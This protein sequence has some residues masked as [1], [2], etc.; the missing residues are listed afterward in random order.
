MEKIR[1]HSVL[2]VDDEVSNI[3]ALTHIL[4]KEYV[5]YASRDGHDALESAEEHLPDVILLDIIMPEM[6]G[7][8]VL[9][10][11]KSSEI[12]RDIPV[13]FVTGLRESGD[14]ERGLAMGAA[15]YIVKPFSSALVRLRVR[16]QI[17][18]IEKIKKTGQAKSAFLANMS[19]EV[20]T[21]MN[22]VMGITE[23]LLQNEN[24]P[25]EL[26]DG[27]GRIYSSCKMLLGIINDILDF[28]KID[29]GML[30]ILPTRYNVAG[31]INDCVH[32]N[33]LRI[34]EKPIEF[35]VLAD[36]NTPAELIGDGLR[37]KQI[38]NNILSN[39]FK[40]TDSG[41]ITLS[42]ESQPCDEGTTLILSIS[43][44]G[45]GMTSEQVNKLFDE[46]SRFD[47]AH[48][49]DI[50]G[51]GLGMAITQ[52]LLRLMDGSIR[53]ESKPG[54]GSDFTVWLPQKTVSDEVIG[55]ELAEGLH[56]F[57][58]GYTADVA[59][60]R[61]VRE[62]MP[63]G[64]VLIVDDVEMNLYVADGL[65]RLYGLQIDLALSGFEA[66][67][68]IKD[69]KDYDIVFMD[70]IMPKMDGIETAKR[71][72]ELGYGN[73]IIALTANA[74]VGQSD[75]FLQNGFDDFISKPIDIRVLDVILKSLIRD[76]QPPKIQLQARKELR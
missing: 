74:V 53:V 19:H 26:L 5:L 61:F 40:Y 34:C 69:G 54:R 18:L 67:E 21:P 3:L 57:R 29:A 48:G 23:I 39:A 9:S 76:K 71:L 58:L 17:K 56:C 16:N 51:T 6:D 15:D 24:Y 46:Y 65:M 35:E 50:E 25:E 7:Y 59:R 45:S 20:R 41:K 37:V 52:R 12:T 2:I 4:S 31:L 49:R 13:I 10:K 44:T 42:V 43:D 11:L 70:H 55:K 73:P 38:L 33:I 68:K 14:E 8:E 47:E 28:T 64:R 30:D 72:R 60:T 66:I 32:Q 36:E 22:A 62:P 27:L 75:I 1:E 63:Y